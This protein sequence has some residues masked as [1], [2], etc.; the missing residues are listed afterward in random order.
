[1]WFH[2]TDG[3]RIFGL[4]EINHSFGS[5]PTT[6]LRDLMPESAESYALRTRFP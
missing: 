1:M 4:Q 2:W 6:G 3:E 5:V